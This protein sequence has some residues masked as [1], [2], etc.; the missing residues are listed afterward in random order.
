MYP[1]T[2]V[3]EESDADGHRERRTGVDSEDAGIGE[4]I[5]RERLDESAGQSEAHPD[6]EAEHGPRVA[7]LEDDELVVAACRG[8]ECTD[9]LRQGHVPGA[10]RQRGED[11]EDEHDE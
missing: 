10:D 8:E 1:L 11:D 6:E 4:R 7:Q 2:E 3:A 5:A 9:D